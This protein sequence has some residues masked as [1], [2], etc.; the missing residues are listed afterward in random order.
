MAQFFWEHKFSIADISGIFLL[1]AKIFC[2]VG[3]FV[4]N[5][6]ECRNGDGQLRSTLKVAISCTNLVRFDMV[7]P[8][9]RLL[10]FYLCETRSS[11][12]AE[13]LR[14]AASLK[15]DNIALPTKYNYQATSVSR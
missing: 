3:G 5:G 1:I 11:A 15:I 13:G 8:E 14:D 9:K 4:R 2:M 6:L 12:M 7:T 10:I